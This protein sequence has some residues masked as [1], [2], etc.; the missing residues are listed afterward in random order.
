VPEMQQQKGDPSTGSRSR[1]D[2]QEELDV[3]IFLANLS[4]AGA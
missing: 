3:E 4:R 2:I 1:C